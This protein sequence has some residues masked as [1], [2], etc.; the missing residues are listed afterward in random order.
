MRSSRKQSE[1]QTRKMMLEKR[2]SRRATTRK[3]AVFPE[4]IKSS[5]RQIKLEEGFE[6]N[7]NFSHEGNAD[8][9]INPF[10]RMKHVRQE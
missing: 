6:I 2:S 7:S 9:K 5:L 8:I 3:T 10:R 4:D 1:L